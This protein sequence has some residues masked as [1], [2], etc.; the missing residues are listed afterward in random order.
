MS[1]KLT[2]HSNSSLLLLTYVWY[3]MVDQTWLISEVTKEPWV[4]YR[5]M[6]LWDDQFGWTL[7][8][9]KT[10]SDMLY[11]AVHFPPVS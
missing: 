5:K 9:E 10:K 3:K 2:F 8:K 11:A 7:G 4:R 1:P 6:Y